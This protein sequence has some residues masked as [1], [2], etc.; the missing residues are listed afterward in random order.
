MEQRR[1]PRAHSQGQEHVADL[2]DGGIGQHALDV[3]LH[4]RRETRHQQGQGADHRHQRQHRGRQREQHVGARDEIDPGRHHGRR[5]DERA[6]RR[7]TGHGVRKPG[8]ERQLGGLA[9]G[10]S[11]QQ[12]RHRHGQARAR[13]KLLAG[14]LEQL[15]DVQR[16]QFGEEQKE[17]HQHGGVAHPGD[18]E[19][20]ARGLAVGL[21]LVEEADQQVAAQPHALP[22]EQEQHQVVRQEQREHGAHEQVHVRE[23]AAVALFLLHH[24]L[25]GV[26]VDQEAHERHHEDHGQRQGVQIEGEGG[27]KTGHVEPHPQGLCE[28]RPRGRRRH[29]AQPHHQGDH[30][31]QADGAHAHAG[32][33]GPREARPGQHENEGA[34]E[35]KGGYQ[36]EQLE[37]VIPSSDSRRPR[38]G[39]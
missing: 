5:V 25:D 17:R 9:H 28:T 36:P 24:V 18:D 14:A 31:G 26:E 32:H 13:L 7:G 19:R 29:E 10:S 27:P 38:P 23:E 15:L 11:Q 33:L 21:V 39:C 37:H 2:A 4:Q 35:R 3:V 30:R 22:A 8:L 16:A 34:Q 6:H 12:Q 20:L 1:G